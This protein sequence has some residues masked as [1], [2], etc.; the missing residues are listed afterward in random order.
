MWQY[1]EAPAYIS[2]FDTNSYSTS[3]SYYD[4]IPSYIE[5]KSTQYNTVTSDIISTQNVS[6]GIY[7]I[8]HTPGQVVCRYNNST[9]ILPLSNILNF[10]YINDKQIQDLNILN[11]DIIQDVIIIVHETGIIFNKIYINADGKITKSAIPVR[12]ININPDNMILSRYFYNESND[13]VL[14]T[15]IT[16]EIDYKIDDEN[17]NTLYPT[18]YKVAIDDLHCDIIYDPKKD[19]KELLKY[20]IDSNLLNHILS[21]DEP[22][23]FYNSLNDAFSVIYNVHDWLGYSHT[24]N[25]TFI[26]QHNKVELIT[27]D[28]YLAD[29]INFYTNIN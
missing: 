8:R 9:D 21:I 16:K 13:T 12:I 7:D 10:I 11:F 20:S 14:F 23:T 26:L 27:S 17:V 24:L 2:H 4:N 18:I 5:N 22:I 15:I 28:L 19:D 29:N 6:G 1:H 3:A 25:S